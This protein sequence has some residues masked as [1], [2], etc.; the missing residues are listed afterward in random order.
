MD[1][2]AQQE[3]ARKH[4]LKLI[5][6]FVAAVIAVVGAVALTVTL[7]QM[8]FVPEYPLSRRFHQI[9]DSVVLV[10]IVIFALKR[11]YKLRGGGDAIAK[12]VS[13]RAVKRDTKDL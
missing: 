5:R 2:F 10:A 3:S 11:L 13:A 12:M 9:L 8:W 6:M 7:G 1:F 4:T